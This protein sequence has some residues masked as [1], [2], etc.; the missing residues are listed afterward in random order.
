MVT[1]LDDMVGD[2]MKKLHE[3][4]L[5][6]QTIIIFTS[7]Y[8]P[9]LE[10]GADP[11]YFNSN[12]NLRGYKR[13]VYE[14]GIRVPM[15]ARWPG[16]IQA[17]TVS[18]H[19]SAFWDWMPTIADLIDAD[20]GAIETDGISL[21]PELLGDGNQRQ[22][23]SLYWEFHEQ[24]GR[25]GV[26]AGDWKLVQYGAWSDSPGEFELYNLRDD[27]SETNDVASQFPEKIAELKSIMVAQRT[28]S[29]TFEQH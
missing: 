28:A 15:I 3:L 16:R 23:E 6:E 11:D 12:G 20:P 10:G 4:G 1:L 17:G 14:G 18:E 26:R 5:D 21:L 8:G 7:D 22:H 9:H 19:I 29:P 13:D 2:I 24:G 27:I 25:K